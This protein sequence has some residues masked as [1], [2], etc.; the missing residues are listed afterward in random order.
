MERTLGGNCGPSPLTAY[1]VEQAACRRGVVAARV[2]QARAG[3]A[4]RF[5]TVRVGLLRDWPRLCVRAELDENLS[6]PYGAPR[7]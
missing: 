1:I 3:A 5:I 7:E 2:Q 4:D 6:G